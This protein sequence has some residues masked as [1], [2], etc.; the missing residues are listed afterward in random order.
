MPLRE[1]Q[2]AL[3][4]AVSADMVYVLASEFLFLI[5]DDSLTVEDNDPILEEDGD[6]FQPL[7]TP[8]A[9][10]ENMLEDKV[11]A[12]PLAK[13]RINIAWESNEGSFKTVQEYE[14]YSGN[15]ELAKSY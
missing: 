14:T 3:Y 2:F 10:L 6:I 9:I 13:W 12:E 5:P 15:L 11:T 8:E 1:C 4:L 7:Y